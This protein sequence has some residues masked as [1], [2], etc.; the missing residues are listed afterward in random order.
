M[1][2]NSSS[3][4]FTLIELLV[5]IAIIAILAAILF[6]VFAKAREKARQT[7][8]MSNQRQIALSIQL[9]TQDNNEILP[10]ANSWWTTLAISPKVLQ[11]LT[12]GSA[13]ANA[14]VYHAG[15]GGVPLQ[16]LPGNLD[17]TLCFLTA[18]GASD[19]LATSTPATFFPQVGYFFTDI[20]S[21]RH[22]NGYI[23]SFVDGH[24]EYKKSTST[25]IQVCLPA[26]LGG[27]I[28]A[29]VIPTTTATMP[30]SANL[31]TEGTTAWAYWNSSATP[32]SMTGTSLFSNLSI[33]NS[34]FGGTDQN[35]IQFTW[36]N[37][38]PTTTGTASYTGQRANGSGAQ[39][40]FSESF[41]VGPCTGTH[42]CYVYLYSHVWGGNG[43]FTLSATL[44][45][46][47]VTVTSAPVTYTGNWVQRVP[48]TFTTFVSGESVQ[49]TFASTGGSNGQHDLAILGATLQ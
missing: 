47:G 35:I 26:S 40:V 11:C 9:Y 22:D 14:Y 43:I 48:I 49:V 10:A 24:V 6:P 23:A 29:P 8:C 16:A 34:T 2:R 44:L 3:K 13:I 31:T 20:A 5:V 33:A 17:P 36:T 30:L 27:S 21:S 41:T 1:S 46:S 45:T 7:Q 39:T 42:T 19:P 37:G 18:D 12:A 28:G 4:G 38:N 32:I 15:C 25:P